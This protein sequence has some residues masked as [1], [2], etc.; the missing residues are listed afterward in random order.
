MSFQ[1]I[2]PTA[3]IA[4]IALLIA[5]FNIILQLKFGKWKESRRIQKEIKEKNKRLMELLKKGDEKSKKEADELQKQIL[6][7]TFKP[8]QNMTKPMLINLAV[9]VIIWPVIGATY[10]QAGYLISI[11]WDIP[12]L[13][14]KWG[15]LKWYIVTA[16]V[17]SGIINL[18]LGKLE[19]K[20]MI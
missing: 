13:G 1:I 6:A 17:F 4:I 7:D 9:I 11:P 8:M 5:V 2:N 20:G 10:S 19:E 3:D 16:F 15:W 18:I 14:A 12:I